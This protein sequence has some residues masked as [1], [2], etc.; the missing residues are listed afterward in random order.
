MMMIVLLLLI[1]TLMLGMIEML[2][3]VLAMLPMSIGM[4]QPRQQIQAAYLPSGW[5]TNFH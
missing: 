1:M 4:T 3:L 5:T 2:M